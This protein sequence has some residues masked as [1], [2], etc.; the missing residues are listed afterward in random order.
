MYQSDQT[1]IRRKAFSLARTWARPP[2]RPPL[3]S[4]C[5]NT[6]IEENPSLFASVI[7]PGSKVIKFPKNQEV[8]SGT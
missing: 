8:A 2:G 4:H 3:L 6:I 5:H 7:V 1:E